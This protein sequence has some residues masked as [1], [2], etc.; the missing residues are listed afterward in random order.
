MNALT[1]WQPYA[2]LIA[3]GAKSYETRSWQTDYR[4]KLAIHAGK[5]WKDDQIKLCYKQP[6]RDLLKE[7]GFGK[8]SELPR[9]AVVAVTELQGIAPTEGLRG[10]VGELERALGNYRNGRFGWRLLLEH[11]LDTPAPATGNRGLW[12]WQPEDPAYETGQR[13]AFDS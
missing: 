7:A 12:D 1:L 10:Q 2:S 4:G 8:A 13:T 5:R 9:G 6:I 3:I 11:R